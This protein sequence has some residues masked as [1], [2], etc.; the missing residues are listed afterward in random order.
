MNKEQIEQEA[1][2]YANDINDK[3]L[4]IYPQH[5]RPQVFPVYSDN[6]LADAF[7]SGASW[8]ISS[9]WHKPTAYGEE[10]KGDVE[11]IVHCKIGYHLGKFNA[12]GSFHEY[13]GFVSVSG[14]EF[15][16]SDIL[17]YAYLDDLLPER[18]EDAE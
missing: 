15:A 18:K 14:I 2:D 12:V 11:V 17:E 10:L 7:K 16:L 5:I 6:D 13:I 8:R 4:N 3:M 1:Y 9:V